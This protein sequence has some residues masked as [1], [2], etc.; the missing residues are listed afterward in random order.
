MKNDLILI[1]MFTFETD[2]FLLEIN[3]EKAK[4]Q[5]DSYEALVDHVVRKNKEFVNFYEE[6][7]TPL[8]SAIIEANFTLVKALIEYGADVDIVVT[9]PNIQKYH[10][11]NTL[12]VAQNSVDMY[13]KSKKYGEFLDIRYISAKE[14]L[15]FIELIY[16]H[17]NLNS[18]IS[19]Q[20]NQKK[21]IK[22]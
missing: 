16:E 2:D 19:H 8:H 10:G 20:H 3:T 5:F 7:Y 22:L 18:M 11:K 1:F 4:A 12:E 9:N 14:I 15:A 21:Q 13:K 6:G 17:K